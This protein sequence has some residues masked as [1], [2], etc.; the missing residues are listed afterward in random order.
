MLMLG[1]ALSQFEKVW[2][3]MFAQNAPCC[4]CKES[5]AQEE[6]GRTWVPGSFQDRFVLEG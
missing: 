2:P 4:S 6:S 3:A 5:L 1:T